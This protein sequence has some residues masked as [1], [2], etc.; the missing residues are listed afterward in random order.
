[1]SKAFGI[2]LLAPLPG[3]LIESPW[4]LTAGILPPYW[5]SKSFL[6]DMGGGSLFGIFTVTGLLIHVA[7]IYLLLGRFNR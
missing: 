6:A 1:L 5:V 7:Y 2:F 3:Y 4:Q